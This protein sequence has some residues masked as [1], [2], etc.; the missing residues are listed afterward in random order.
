MDAPRTMEPAEAEARGLM[1]DWLGAVA[2]AGRKGRVAARSAVR[3]A[4]R[5]YGEAPAFDCEEPE[6][7]WVPLPEGGD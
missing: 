6:A 3:P 2:W 7:G 1:A 5:R 4:L